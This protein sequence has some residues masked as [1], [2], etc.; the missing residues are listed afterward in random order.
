MSDFNQYTKMNSNLY[1]KKNI[2]GEE[3]GE[4]HTNEKNYIFIDGDIW[5]VK[6]IVL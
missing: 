6:L 5:N 3:M 1:E 4:S 2:Q